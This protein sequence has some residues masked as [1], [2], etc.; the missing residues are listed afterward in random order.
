MFSHF[1]QSDDSSDIARL[2]AKLLS[3]ENV[4]TANK[5][6]VLNLDYPNAKM[7]N[8][9][10]DLKTDD[11]EFT[12]KFTEKPRTKVRFYACFIGFCS[13]FVAA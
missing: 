4:D 3:E 12:T 8:V 13:S 5:M 11:K 1:W 2:K 9:I 10:Y 7:D 6:S